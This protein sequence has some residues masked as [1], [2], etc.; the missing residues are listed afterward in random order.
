MISYRKLKKA[1]PNIGF[2]YSVIVFSTSCL[3]TCLY[4]VESFHPYRH[5]NLKRLG[6]FEKIFLILYIKERE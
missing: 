4:L 2:R 5:A 6:L 1:K 3:F